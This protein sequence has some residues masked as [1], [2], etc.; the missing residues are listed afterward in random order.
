MRARGLLVVPMALAL[1]G[2]ADTARADGP[3]DAQAWSRVG[4][5]PTFLP[6]DD[7]IYVAADLG[8]E[9]ARSYVHVDTAALPT[10]SD[11]E[12]V[13]R[14]TE[15]AGASMLA[16]TATVIACPLTTPIV[17][18]GEVTAEIAPS[19]DC[20]SSVPVSRTAEGTWSVPLEPFLAGWRA[21]PE[22]GLGLVATVTDTDT[23]HVALD[24][25]KTAV[26]VV[27]GLSGTS[28]DPVGAGLG[29]PPEAD[30]A[31]DLVESPV[32]APVGDVDLAT[33]AA[34]TVPARSAGP[35]PASTPTAAPAPEPQLEV[36]PVTVTSPPAPVVLGVVALAAL[37]ASVVLGRRRPRPLAGTA[38]VPVRAA[39]WGVG[40]AGAIVL[41]AL[42]T[43]TTTY[44]LGLVL[45]LLVAATGLHLLVTWA[46]ELS[47]AHASLVGLP[48]F[49]V[50]KLSADHG[51]SPVLLLPVGVAVGL[52]AGAV[53]GIPA[54]RARGLQV[55]LVTLAAGVAIDRFFFT[56]E[57]VVGSVSGN[58]V[59]TPSLGPL[60]FT[61][62]RSMY[63]LLALIT[64]L[65]ILA[66]WAIYRSKLGRAL[67][68][69]KAQPDAAAAFGIP[70]A[71]YRA[72]AYA[73]AGGFAGLAG[74]L[75]TM[76]VQ[77]LTP[78]AFPLSRSFTF[79]IIVALAGR[80]FLG[81]VA[82]AAVVIEGGQLF[83]ASGN[84]LITYGAP[85]GLIL[86]LT[87]HPAGLNGFGRQM[88][89][90]LR[91]IRP[92][93]TPVM[94]DSNRLIRPLLAA[95]TMSAATGFASIVLAWYHAGNTSQLWIQNQEMILGGLGGLGL[96]IVGV[97][98]VIYDRLL[99]LRTAEAERWERM[100]SAVE[101]SLADADARRAR[102]PRLSAS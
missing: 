56:K 48:A 50:A 31:P 62:S 83:L 45:I 27:P 25:T 40:A 49:V 2:H 76:W 102:R 42:L 34:V 88:A 43:E 16:D 46:G 67:L 44:K 30:V 55:A 72:M 19:V 12:L 63:P 82:L 5:L 52:L 70:V 11:R 14:L 41:P 65:T 68:W 38:G 101:T 36:G 94:T 86:T 64:T 73:L 18:Q 77:R 33:L 39:G 28:A 9:T 47:L 54:I 1:L 57:W 6:E 35:A 92:G 98:L 91:S 79:L 58:P 66:A 99:V 15:V 97:A 13:L 21:G 20:S 71:R 100:L 80:G 17:G 22:L 81:G 7:R 78:E 87:R 90:R 96:V 29:Q 26:V 10:G 4:L 51:V 85:I 8:E 61:T 24:A 59:A 95:G 93:G 89:H 32:F 74:G 3:V 60:S 75:T 69:I 84:A 37:G 53:V 23:F